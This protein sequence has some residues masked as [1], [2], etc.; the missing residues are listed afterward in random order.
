MHITCCH[1]YYYWS[2][3]RFVQFVVQPNR[4]LFHIFLHDFHADIIMLSTSTSHPPVA[5]FVDPKYL[6]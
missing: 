6:N 1:V 2:D 3:G 4:A 5:C